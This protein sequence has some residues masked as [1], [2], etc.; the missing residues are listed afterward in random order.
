MVNTG[1]KQIGVAVVIEIAGSRSHRISVACEFRGCSHVGEFHIPVVSEEPIRI[2][3]R[4]FLK[5]GHIGA[6]GEVDIRAAVVIVIEDC[7]TSRHRFDHPFLGR[8]AILQDERHS[9][10]GCDIFKTDRP[11]CLKS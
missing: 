10:F 3:R 4:A 7:Q 1:Y 11:G 6:I 5:R 2:F 9:G 8:R